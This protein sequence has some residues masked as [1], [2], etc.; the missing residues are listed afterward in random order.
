MCH[1][2]IVARD[3]RSQ[4]DSSPYSMYVFLSLNDRN[5]GLQMRRIAL[6]LVINPLCGLYCGAWRL[7]RKFREVIPWRMRLLTNHQ[8]RRALNPRG[9]P[10]I[11]PNAFGT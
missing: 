2:Y 10:T 3:L 9:K 6:K 7:G 8:V 11:S 5:G 4:I 1:R